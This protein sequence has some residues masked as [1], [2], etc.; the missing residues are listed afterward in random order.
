MLEY[1]W[2][3]TTPEVYYAI[4][5]YHK[6]DLHCFESYTD[7][8][9]SGKQLKAQIT[10]WGFKESQHPIIRSELRNFGEWTYY[11]L[12]TAYGECE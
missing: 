2:I 7:M 12:L 10:G 8:E 9:L 5:N 3:K 11:L 1:T 6:E 4:Y